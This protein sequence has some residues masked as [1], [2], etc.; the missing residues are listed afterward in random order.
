MIQILFHRSNCIGCNAC[1]EA[2][3]QRWRVSKRDGRCKLIGSTEKKGVYKVNV[4]HDEHDQNLQASKNCPVGIIK[5]KE[6]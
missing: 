3:P 5:V 2:A 6:L 1:V 4:S